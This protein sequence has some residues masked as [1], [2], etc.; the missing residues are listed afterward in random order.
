MPANMFPSTVWNAMPAA[1]EMTPI[2]PKTSTGFTLGNTTVTAAPRE[3]TVIPTVA[4]PPN[5][6]AALGLRP[7]RVRAQVTP[8]PTSRPR[9]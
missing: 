2:P 6:R 3:S 8:A 4:M 5:T 9:T 1:I 7:R